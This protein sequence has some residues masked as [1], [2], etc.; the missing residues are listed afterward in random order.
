MQG[1]T[2]V[3]TGNYIDL[4]AVLAGKDKEVT[5]RTDTTSWQRSSGRQSKSPC[6]LRLEF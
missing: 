4:V 6:P 5:A 2:E 1:N 3:V